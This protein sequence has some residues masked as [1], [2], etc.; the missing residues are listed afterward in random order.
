MYQ[1][2]ADQHGMNNQRSR[3][4]PARISF[5]ESILYLCP[6][7]GYLCTHIGDIRAML[8][9]ARQAATSRSEPFRSRTKL[10]PANGP[11]TCSEVTPST[12]RPML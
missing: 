11:T 2:S 7:Y 12:S 3:Y 10:L 5:F 8:Y 1:I 4:K 9:A 6:Q